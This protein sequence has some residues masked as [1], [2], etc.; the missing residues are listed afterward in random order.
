MLFFIVKSDYLFDQISTN[1]E[2]ILKL[3]GIFLLES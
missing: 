1:R 2:N 3:N